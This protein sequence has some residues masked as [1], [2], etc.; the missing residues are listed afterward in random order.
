MYQ[1][2]KKA[3]G[4][5]ETRTPQEDALFRHALSSLDVIYAHKAMAS[6]LSTRL[7]TGV[8]LDRG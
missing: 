3:A 4:D 1:K 2:E 7:P 6:L 5:E 8:Q